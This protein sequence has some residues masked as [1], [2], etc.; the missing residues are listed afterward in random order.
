MEANELIQD[1]EKRES[2]PSLLITKCE[3][4]YIIDEISAYMGSSARGF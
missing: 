4:P 3:E 2:V 1:P